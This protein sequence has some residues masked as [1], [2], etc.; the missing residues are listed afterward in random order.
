MTWHEVG[1]AVRELRAAGMRVSIDSFDRYEVDLACRAGAELVL[2]VNSTNCQHA[3]DWN[4]EVVV[5]PDTPDEE[6]KF[7]ETIDFLVARGVKVRLDPYSR[8][9]RL[10]HRARSGTLWT[11]AQTLC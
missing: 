11:R 6:K 7:F 5:V 4:A 2:S 10:W 9:D 3:L 8:T 1:T